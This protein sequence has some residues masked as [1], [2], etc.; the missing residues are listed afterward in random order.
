MST[1]EFSEEFET[2]LSS[3]LL[4]S[5][6]GMQD[7]WAFNEYEKSVFL[8]SA[9]Q[10]YVKSLYTGKNVSGESFE[11][12]EDIAELLSP[13][14]ETVDYNIGVTLKDGTG[15]IK[16][17]NTLRAGKQFKHNVFKLPDNLMYIFYEEVMIDPELEDCCKAGQTILVQPIKHDE[18]YRITRNPFRGPN[19]NRAL[20]L[21]YSDNQVEI[22]SSVPIGKYRVRYIRKPKPIILE[23]LIDNSID[24]YNKDMTCELDDSCHR[25]ILQMA[26]QIALA[27]KRNAAS[28]ISNK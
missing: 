15:Y 19:S 2:L 7:V 28:L 23:E 10:E 25:T 18:Y 6:I 24:G 9:Q 27:S 20:R 5:E 1:Q 8:T 12:T 11:L 4:P 3:F 21:N 14:H 17:T 16:N 26:V 22:I 13:L